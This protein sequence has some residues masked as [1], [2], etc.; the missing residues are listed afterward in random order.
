MSDK[1]IVVAVDG[2]AASGK[3]TVSRLV[4]KT[5]GFN[6][7]DTGA[8]YR[9]VTWKAIEEDID[10]DDT[11]SVI[12]MMHRIKIDFDLVDK[13]VRMLIDGKYPGNAIRE[14]R[15]TEKVSAISAIPEVRQ[16]LVQ[17]QRS[18]TKFGSLVMEGRDIGTVVF[19]DTPYKFYLE[20]NTEV[21]AAR[22]K[23]DLE[24]M[25]IEASEEGV[26]ESIQRRDKKDSG[27]NVSPLQIA[28]GATVVD[29]SKLSAEETT[30]VIVDHIRQQGTKRG[31]ITA[32]IRSPESKT[33][34]NFE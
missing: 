8:M 30:K 33:R 31:S 14:P 29:N 11:I 20:A 12:A 3:S 4:A 10:A 19:P 26:K 23:R 2:P 7:V 27:R 25:K 6:Y 15:V 21:R 18:L 5:L 1:I 16:V 24:A 28:L 22:R 9:S 32:E 17:H 34:T 13:Q